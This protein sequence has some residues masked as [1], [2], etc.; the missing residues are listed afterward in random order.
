MPSNHRKFHGGAA[1]L[2]VTAAALLGAGSAHSQL[3]ITELMV[4]PTSPND[5]AWEWMEVRNTGAVAI[6]LNGALFAKLGEADSPVA[7]ISNSTAA[8]TIVPAGGLAVLYAGAVTGFNDQL[9]RTAWGLSPNVP[10]IAVDGFP[11][12]A[13]SGLSRNVGL[14]TDANAYASALADDGKGTM[15]VSSF[16]GAA[17]SLDYSSDFPSTSS[18]GPSLVWSGA[19]NNADGANWSLS[20]IDH[21]AT[22][23]S[24]IVVTGS[25]VNNIQDLGSPGRVP[26]GSASPGLLITEIMYDPASADAAWEWVEIYNNSGETI[27]FGTR[28]HLFHDT[29]TAN[30][31]DLTEANIRFG[32]LPHGKAAVLFDSELSAAAFSE[33]WDPGGSLG[34]IFIPVDNFPSLNNNGDTIAIWDSLSDYVADAASITPNRTTDLAISVVTY[35]DSSPW[36]TTTG[37]QSI[38]LVNLASPASAGA[39]WAR[40]QA[41]DLVGSTVASPVLD[42]VAIHPGGDI[43]SPGTFG[44]V[45]PG[46]DADFNNDN[47]VD[48]RDF[49]IWQRGFGSGTNNATGDADGNGVVNAADLTVWKN[50]FGGP[51]TVGAIGAVPEPTSLVLCGLAFAATA[52]SRRRRAK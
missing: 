30:S 48:G 1:S 46:L 27:N 52:V 49:L 11:E 19:G 17:F 6:D 7:D 13:N 14:W 51:P 33:A 10:L 9:F 12:L 2:I 31:G 15:R 34:T 39:S 8:N 45:S 23:S 16:V 37:R 25:P 41:G 44:A 28:H 22:T 18:N 3:L 42:E 5:T 24:P 50:T 38:Q 4:N 36:P 43:G 40:S 26:P 29:T 35:D 21:G 32:T 47:V 20:S